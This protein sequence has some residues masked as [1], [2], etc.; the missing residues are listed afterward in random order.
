MDNPKIRRVDASYE[1]PDPNVVNTLKRALAAAEAGTLRG[2]VVVECDRLGECKVD[3]QIGSGTR[4][5]SLL[6]A[7]LLAV[8]AVKAGQEIADV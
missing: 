8:D 2:V 5:L 3:V 4:L 1:E 7:T 6:G